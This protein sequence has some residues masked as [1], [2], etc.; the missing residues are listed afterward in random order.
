LL[1]DTLLPPLA[2]TVEQLRKALL[3]QPEPDVSAVTVELAKIVACAG[4]SA[5]PHILEFF[6]DDYPFPEVLFPLL[7]AVES[8]ENEAYASGMCESLPILFER[9]PEWATTF[10]IR[11]LNCAETLGAFAARAAQLQPARK[12][13]LR[14][15][16]KHTSAINPES[17]SACE[18]ILRM[19]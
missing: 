12:E 5:I 4:A 8:I 14:R 3:R 11:V 16:V 2:N 10:L 15:L 19:I 17:A 13:L 7:H 6:D 9:A 1:G 18:F